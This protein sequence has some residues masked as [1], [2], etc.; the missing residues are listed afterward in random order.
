MMFKGPR[1]MFG[2]C[3]QPRGSL[4]EDDRGVYRE[5]NREVI[6]DWTLSRELYEDKQGEIIIRSYCHCCC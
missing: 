2:G 4:E 1:P 3:G 6:T 5:R